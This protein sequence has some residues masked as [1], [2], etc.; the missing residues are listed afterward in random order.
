MT[1]SSHTGIVSAD[2]TSKNAH[3]NKDVP[4]SVMS[5]WRWFTSRLC[6]QLITA[7]SMNNYLNIAF[8]DKLHCIPIDMAID[9]HHFLTICIHEEVK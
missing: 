6:Y 2:I 7:L 5:Y 8:F 9:S 4:V 3:R 1:K